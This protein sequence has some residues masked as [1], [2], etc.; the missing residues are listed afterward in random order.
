MANV[1][2][3]DDHRETCA[4]L[5]RMFNRQGH[6]AACVT[7]GRA[8]LEYVRRATP[9]FIVLDFMMPD[10]D[11]LAVLRELRAQPTTAAVP[12]AV[13]TAVADPRF[14]IYARDRGAN[15]VWVK[16]SIGINDMIERMERILA[17]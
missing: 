12:V 8:A 1:L 7:D 13:Y 2:V 14:E 3:V 6:V 16:A 5:V 4:L 10:M 9:D 11:G 17:A 15:D